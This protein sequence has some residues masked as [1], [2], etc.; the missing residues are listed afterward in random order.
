M[1]VTFKEQIDFV[2]CKHIRIIRAEVVRE[3]N[4][5]GITC[6]HT[7]AGA[8]VV[9]D[10]RRREWGSSVVVAIEDIEETALTGLCWCI[11]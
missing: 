3:T 11:C 10:R 2:D 5:P 1:L 6:W 7:M 9:T 4:I 8:S